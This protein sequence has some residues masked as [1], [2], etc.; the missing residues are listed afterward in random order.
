VPLQIIE[1]RDLTPLQ[2]GVA[3]IPDGD[4]ESV[5]LKTFTGDFTV[6]DNVRLIKISGEGTILW[7]AGQEPEEFTS[8]EFRGVRPGKTFTVA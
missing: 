6:G 1:F 8:T 2:N 3:Q 5:S 4:P 7:T